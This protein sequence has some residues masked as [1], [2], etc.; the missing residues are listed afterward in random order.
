MTGA[1]TKLAVLE[2]GQRRV[3]S[4]PLAGSPRA[5]RERRRAHRRRRIQRP[6][7]SSAIRPWSS[8][9]R[10]RAR[11]SRAPR[12]RSCPGPSGVP[13]PSSGHKTTLDRFRTI[14]VTT[15]F[16]HGAELELLRGARRGNR[17]PRPRRGRP[18]TPLD[19]LPRS[20]ERADVA[21]LQG[22]AGSTGTPRTAQISPA[23]S[24]ANLRGLITRVNID[25]RSR[26]HSWL[27]IYHDMGLAFILVATLGQ[28][29]LWQ[30]PTQAF[31][32]NPFGWLKWLTESQATMTAAPNMAFN[33]IGKYASG[34]SGLQSE[35]PRLHA[36][37]RR[38][39]RLR[40]LSNASPTRWPG[41]ASTRTRSPRPMG[42]PNPPVR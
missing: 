40:G 37:R 15:V 3:D 28:A 33:L 32:G 30:A 29:D 1:P 14:G 9:P 21:I 2:H 20:P 36:Q 10:S 4:P 41:S 17:R 38:T 12:C 26:L 7:A 5:C 11:S 18:R 13:I 6:S 34:L 31:A 8:S 19:H 35:Q 27:P 39:R 42:W 22:T 16:S 25:D 23:A 24:L